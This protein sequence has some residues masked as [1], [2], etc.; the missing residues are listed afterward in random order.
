MSEV[1][2]QLPPACSIYICETVHTQNTQ[3]P[4][5][6]TTKKKGRTCQHVMCFQPLFL[7]GVE[8][9]LGSVQTTGW[10]HLSPHKHVGSGPQESFLAFKET[11]CSRSKNQSKSTTWLLIK[12]EKS[13]KMQTVYQWI[14]LP[15]PRTAS[16]GFED[17]F[18]DFAKFF[19]RRKKNNL[20]HNIFG[21]AKL[22]VLRECCV[23]KNK[24]K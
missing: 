18:K 13:G 1:Q 24:K 23:K 6:H 2:L 7:K 20:L 5:S 19:I 15:N 17:L 9:H 16:P 11:E 22:R 12:P 4:L 8:T 21:N 3:P 14:I 10:V